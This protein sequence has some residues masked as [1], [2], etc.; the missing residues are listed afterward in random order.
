MSRVPPDAVNSEIRTFTQAVMSNSRQAVLRASALQKLV[1]RFSAS[2]VQ[3]LSPDA[4]EKWSTMIREQIIGYQRSVAAV[5]NDL[6]RI[7]PAAGSATAI[8]SAGSVQEASAQLLRISFRNDDVIRRAF[9]VAEE[10][11]GSAAF[12]AELWQS[13][14]EAEQLAR[15]IQR[16]TP[17]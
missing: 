6:R 4:R 17:R 9:T 14:A 5:R 1:Q 2:D 15:E 10:N 12:S 8:V 7:Y 11:S 13:L 16:L 3:S